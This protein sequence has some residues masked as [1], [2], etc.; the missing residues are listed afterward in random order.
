[1]AHDY[2]EPRSQ[3]FPRPYTRFVPA[4]TPP[5]LA[6]EDVAP[7][8][9][10]REASAPGEPKASSR[11]L[12]S[13]EITLREGDPEIEQEWA[14][15]RTLAVIKV[16]LTTANFYVILL[17]N[18]L[19]V[20][21]DAASLTTAFV[22]AAAFWVYTAGALLAVRFRKI[23]IRAYEWLTP[24]LDVAFSA[25]LIYVTDGY[26]S[27]FNTWL[28][29]AVVATGFSPDRRIPVLTTALAVGVHIAISRIPQE[30][31]L[32]VALLAVRASYPFGFA[33]MVV[34]LGGALARQARALG[35]VERTGAALGA[36]KT[37]DEASDLLF[38]GIRR[39]LGA[40]AVELSREEGMRRSE[41]LNATG[42]KTMQLQVRS[43][44][45]S[46]AE[47]QISRKRAFSD[48]ERRWA[49]L[50][51][52]RYATCI[53][54]LRLADELLHASMQ[55]ERMR[56]ADE[57]HDGH[58]QTLTAL[59]LFLEGKRM[60]GTGGD[61]DEVCGLVRQA[62]QQARALLSPRNEELL[63]GEAH[64][65]SIFEDRWTG[66][67]SI[68]FSPG[69]E[70]TEGMWGVLGTLVKEG[71]NNARRHAGATKA[72]L[73]VH[74]DNGHIAFV[75]ETNGRSP[76]ARVQFGYG[77]TSLKMKAEAN[78]G[79]MS[80]ARGSKGGACLS[81]VFGEIAPS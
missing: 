38:M 20:K 68:A 72:T 26:A 52:E 57:M 44:S 43:G 2:S 7:Y 70:L 79:R 42:S 76:D 37:Q 80:L 40:P 33:A 54:R 53:R 77:L 9:R 22:A 78:G 28:V 61:F 24:I 64:I 23:T 3:A 58:L 56:M 66:E 32:S 34:A 27:P 69:L 73:Q 46:I 71:L 41:N 55:A 12:S 25:V 48:S 81:V 14:V 10:T 4:T 6:P 15:A 13:G 5:L 31:P 67:Q 19:P 21:S 29:L 35:V 60:R 30:E 47:V 36:A 16:I 74:A 1:M 18:P 11:H 75:L 39:L 63:G 45:L 62:T 8:K 59:G 50:L 65:R 17:D 49:E 51:A